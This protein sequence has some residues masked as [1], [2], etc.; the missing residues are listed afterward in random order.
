[1]SGLTY[2]ITGASRGIGKGLLSAFVLRPNTTVIA[3][4]RDTASAAESLKS[5]PVGEGSKIVIVKID[6]SVDTDAAAAVEE[7]KSK[8]GITHIDVLLSNA[9][10]LGIVAPVLETPADQLRKHIEINTVAP[11]ILLQAFKPLLDA[12]SSPKFFV[13]TSKIGTLSDMQNVPVPFFA[14]GVSKAAAN[15]FVRKVS[16]ENPKLISIALNPGWVQTD[17][18]TWGAKSV[19][20][21]EAPMSLED[22]IKGTVKNIDEASLEKTGSFIEVTGEPIPW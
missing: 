20:M 5:V 18:G 15:Y 16:F 2:L 17:M 10:L 3:G 1:M 11:L 6:S 22:S 13:I 9:G 7:L 8:H 21:D 4:V 19:G 14:Y 12:S